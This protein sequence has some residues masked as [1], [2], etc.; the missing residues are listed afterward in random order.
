MLSEYSL[1]TPDR[2]S[3]SRRM[4]STSSSMSRILRPFPRPW[5]GMDVSPGHA[6]QMRSPSPAEFLIICFFRPVP[7]ARSSVT[8]TV[9]QTMPKTVRNVRSFWLRTSRRSWRNTSFNVAID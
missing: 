9:P 1:E 8:A 4:A 5:N 3:A 6:M 2:P 7:N